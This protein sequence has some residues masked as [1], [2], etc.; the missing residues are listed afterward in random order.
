[1]MAV[2]V[3]PSFFQTFADL[4]SLVVRLDVKDGRA[5]I[6]PQEVFQI[7]FFLRP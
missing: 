6:L 5:R 3:E 1:M 2:S 4:L 7:G